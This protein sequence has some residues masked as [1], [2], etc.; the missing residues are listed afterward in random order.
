ML[1]SVEAFCSWQLSVP[2]KPTPLRVTAV[3][4]GEAPLHVT[5]SHA[6]VP[7]GDEPL[8]VASG[9]PASEPDEEPVTETPQAMSIAA[10]RLTAG[11]G[12]DG[13][14]GGSGFTLP[15]ATAQVLNSKAKRALLVDNR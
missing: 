13:G 6:G 8:Q 7:H 11:G 1:S 4:T 3:G 5:P 14:R 10:S 12:G 2:F 9:V 15:A